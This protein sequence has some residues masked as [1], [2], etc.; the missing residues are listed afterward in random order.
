[1]R[2]TWAFASIVSLAPLLA[3]VAACSEDD[4]VSGQGEDGATGSGMEEIGEP[5]DG[6]ESGG[7]D[8]ET[9]GDGDGDGDADPDL[10]SPPDG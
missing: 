2:T 1:M 5:G 6:D 8:G 3:G 10:P 7:Q 4:D 9:N